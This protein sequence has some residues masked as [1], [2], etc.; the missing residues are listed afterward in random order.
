MKEQT[1]T[2]HI[3]EKHPNSIT[4]PY[5]FSNN[6]SLS[7]LSFGTR[8]VSFTNIETHYT[9]ANEITIGKQLSQNLLLPPVSTIHAFMQEE[10]II[11]GP[12]LG[13]FTT[14]FTESKTAPLGSRSTIFTDLLTPP[15]SLQPLV[16]LFGSQH[17]NW[18]AETMDGLFFLEGKWEQ[19][20]I[21]FPNVIYDRLPNRKAESYK[22]IARAKKRLQTK[23]TI[24]WFNPGFFDKWDIH[25]LLI[26]EENIASFLP[27]T[28]AFQHFEQVERLL[29]TYKYVYLKP[30]HG[31]F[32]RNI[33]QIF[34]SQTENKYYCRYRQ[35]EQ[36][37]FRK[38]HSLETLMNHILSG[39]DLKKFIVQQGI[40]L[41]RFN[42]QPMDFRIHTNKNH[43]GNWQVSTIVAKVAGRGS[44]TTHM[45]SGGNV[46]LLHEIFADPT[47]Q[48][49]ITNILSHAALT[50]SSVLDQHIS[51]NIGE[52]GFDIGLDKDENPWLFEAN[53]KPGRSIFQEEKLKEQSEQTRQLFYEYALY[54]TEHAFVFPK[55]KTQENET[56]L[57]KTNLPSTPL[58]LNRER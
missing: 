23:Y 12:L 54:L 10:T 28:E 40:P 25:K 34:Y 52:I 4:L 14:G 56:E 9:L 5:I 37:K 27:R 39:H 51:G 19:H 38:Y 31:S 53:S 57:P 26:K 47:E 49:R 2:L 41:L 21:P 36:N 43:V 17:I 45:N 32:G 16:F 44:M 20:T 55:T 11:L 46:K 1:Y 22:P 6:Q 30:M 3:S 42:G 8:S 18:D 33:Y 58:I 35:N 15:C 50:L 24:P 48:V 29:S 13:I 7:S